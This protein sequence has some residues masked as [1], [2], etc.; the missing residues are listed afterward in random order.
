MSFLIKLTIFR[1]LDQYVNFLFRWEL[2]KVKLKSTFKTRSRS[3]FS[4]PLHFCC[5]KKELTFLVTKNEL[6]FR[7]NQKSNKKIKFECFKTFQIFPEKQKNHHHLYKRLH[8][9]CIKKH[10]KL[11]NRKEKDSH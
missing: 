6:K 11:A 8:N 4:R 10:C 9:V 3:R 1:K 7:K 5:S 2:K